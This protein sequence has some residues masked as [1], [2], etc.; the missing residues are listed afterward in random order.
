MECDNKIRQ[1]RQSRGIQTK[2]KILDT[3][4]ELFCKKGYYKTTT[5]EIARTAGVSIGSL[6]SYFKDKDTILLEILDRY[7][8]SFAKVHDD[9]N[10][11]MSQYRDDPQMW[12]YRFIEGM[13]EIHRNTKELNQELEVL[14]HSM[15][16]VAD[17]MKKQQEKTFQKALTYIVT[18]QKMLRV[19]DL[20]AAA[21]VAANLISSTVD[22]IVFSESKIED[23]RILN[24]GVDAICQ[25]LIG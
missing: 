5:N 23:A 19:R 18:F 20:E 8:E 17:V 14:C 6:Y 3:A 25:Y 10:L 13:I 11:Q 12:F 15:P 2:E 7:N 9:L 4:Y 24:A 21:I 22:Q 16:A 1:P